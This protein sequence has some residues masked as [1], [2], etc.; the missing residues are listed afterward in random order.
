MSFPLFF[1]KI[2]GSGMA[3]ATID[4]FNTPHLSSPE[5]SIDWIT[6]RPNCITTMPSLPSNYDQ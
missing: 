1:T 4:V 6:Q 3:N 2:P 5:T